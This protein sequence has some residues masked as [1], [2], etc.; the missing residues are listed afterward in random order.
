MADNWLKTNL[1]PMIEN[2]ALQNDGLL[3]FAF[4]GSA[5]DDADAGG[6][7]AV[8][9]ISPRFSIVAFQSTTLFQH[10]T[11]LRLMLE[12]LGVTTL[13]GSGVAAPRTWDF[14]TF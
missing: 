1:D 11:V 5:N 12:G 6:R 2:S 4:D 3:L 10:E 13:A 14:F 7:I 8:A 9:L